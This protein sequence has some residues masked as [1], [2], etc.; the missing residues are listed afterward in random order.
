MADARVLVPPVR[1]CEDSTL[2]NA[3]L[4]HRS[5][6]LRDAAHGSIP[7]PPWRDAAQAEA[8]EIRSR[9]SP[10]RLTEPTPYPTA[11]RVAP[12]R[13]DGRAP[14]THRWHYALFSG[15]AVNL[16]RTVEKVGR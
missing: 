14:S 6:Q 10:A 11:S 16:S 9:D 3:S 1:R 7:P 8:A 4:I 12:G 5:R 13:E 2:H 15:R